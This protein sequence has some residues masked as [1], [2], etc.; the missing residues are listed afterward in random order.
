MI[1]FL[2]PQCFDEKD[3]IRGHTRKSVEMADG[4]IAISE[5]S[6]NDLMRILNVPAEKIRV[7]YLANSLTNIPDPENP[8]KSPY[9]LFVGQRF[10]WKNFITLLRAYAHSQMLHEN[11]KLVCFGGWEWTQ[12]EKEILNRP[13]LQNRIVKTSGPDELLA[14]FYS[15]ASAFIYPSLYEGFGLPILEAMH[16]GCPVVASNAGSIPEIAGDAVLYFEPENIEMLQNQI[17]KCLDD[18][19]LR[20]D[21]SQRG[22]RQ[23]A[24]YSWQKC[25]DETYAFYS[26]ILQ[27]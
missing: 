3:K 10:H 8:V 21:L 24:K 27:N 20:D 4:I 26:H 11:Y 9:I 12:E 6:K 23:E 15:H 17:V 14:T 2:F 19:K 16:Y 25:A 1:Y 5:N 18:S 22:I 13:E 7:I